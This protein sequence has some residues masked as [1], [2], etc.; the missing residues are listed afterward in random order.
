M[1]ASGSKEHFAHQSV[2]GIEH[3][4]Y[5]DQTEQH[6]ETKQLPGGG[7]IITFSGNKTK[8]AKEVVPTLDAGCFEVFRPMLE[9]IKS[10]C[11]ASEEPTGS[12]I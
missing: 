6:F 4:F 2:M 11:A 7:E 12:E 3:L 5:G 1:K 9:F 8:F 10:K